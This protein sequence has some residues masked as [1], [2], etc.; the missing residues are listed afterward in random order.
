MRRG[1]QFSGNRQAGRSRSGAR[2]LQCIAASAIAGIALPA[3]ANPV[4]QVG[5]F[6]ASSQSGQSGSTPTFIIY[7]SDAAANPTAEDIE[8]MSFTVQ[9]GAGAD[10][11]PAISNVDLTTNTVW[12]GTD[13]N[14]GGGILPASGNGPQWQS[15]GVL[16]NFDSNT[17]T[18]VVINPNGALGNVT[19]NTAG[20]STGTIAFKMIGTKDPTRDSA[21][22]DGGGLPVPSSI[23]NG[24]LTIVNNPVVY[25][26]GTTSAAWDT[27][28]NWSSAAAP[29]AAQD[30]YFA[31]HVPASGSTIN[32]T[33]VP[34]TVNNLWFDGSYT[35]NGGKINLGGGKVTVFSGSS[36][37][38]NSEIDGSAGLTISGGGNLT[39]GGT[40]AYTGDTTV[41]G[42]TL[43]LNTGIPSGNLNVNGATVQFNGGGQTGNQAAVT[44]T[45]GASPAI[46]SLAFRA[47]QSV[48]S[49]SG[50][51]TIAFPPGQGT[52]PTTLT[53]G[54]NNAST[55]FSGA[56]TGAAIFIKQGTGTL[57]L[58]G[59]NLSLPS[60]RVDA[61]TLNFSNVAPNLSGT[62]LGGTWNVSGTV[63]LPAGSTVT[64][65]A[66][67]ASVILNA[68]TAS[69]PAINT[70][71]NNQGAFWLLGTAG[72]PTSF[73]TA[74]DLTNDGTIILR[75]ANLTVSG[76][77]TNSGT[78]GTSG[79][80]G[81]FGNITAKYIRQS[82]LSVSF[83]K[84]SIRPQGSGGGTSVLG[85]LSLS[86]SSGGSLDGVLD[87][88]D[89]KLIVND[90]TANHAATAAALNSEVNAAA[91]TDPGTAKPRWDS[92]GITSSVIATGGTGGTVDTAHSIGVADNATLGAFQRSSFGG[93]NVNA[94]SI[95]VGYTLSGDGNMDGKVDF[96]DFQLLQGDFNKAGVWQQGD[97][98]HDG[99][100][101]FFDF[102]LLQGNFGKSMP[103]APFAVVTPQQ[104]AEL[105]AFA[106]S[107]PEPSSVGI[108]AMAASALLMS[109]RG[110]KRK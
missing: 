4:V 46:M 5:N 24:T 63:N 51:G 32:L 89:N 54:N 80:I 86:S 26:T 18:G 43:T 69:F 56:I 27:T 40:T 67:G 65:I 37:T 58:S 39:L 3:I 16:T 98:N 34:E 101:N 10:S 81:T 31:N 50:N 57:T 64:T 93:Q 84:A 97:F 29:T 20:A 45:N 41:N 73:T 74:S 103:G 35:Y 85:S 25:W 8:G 13:E 7:V 88:A 83:S 94:A 12:T 76:G 59:T 78:P 9:L 21:F 87:I 42:G 48:G 91:H 106:Q 105:V 90:S 52:Q 75:D 36:V 1:C 30:A 77:L 11:F 104:E 109:R 28:S 68:A 60:I 44:L 47:S 72:S 19:L 14:Q 22:S 62:T 99:Q 110:G 102:Q 23:T 107:V 38:I 6:V 17:N 96:F 82:G 92:P 2:L 108:L 100:V 95:L 55:E 33:S 53:V 79:S 15:Y 61:G 70:L 71:S 66:P 49:L